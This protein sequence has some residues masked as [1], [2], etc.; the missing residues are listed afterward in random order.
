MRTSGISAAFRV[1]G[2]FVQICAVAIALAAPD[3]RVV[4]A[5]MPCAGLCL[6]TL[7]EVIEKFGNRSA[8]PFAPA[9]ISTSRAGD[10]AFRCAN[11]FRA[12]SRQPNQSIDQYRTEG[13]AL[14]NPSPISDTL[15]LESTFDIDRS[16]HYAEE[17]TDRLADVPL[18]ICA[19]IADHGSP[20]NVTLSA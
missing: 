11:D 8:F 15:L 2:E 17:L 13:C 3:W 16:R 18:R 9:I 6:V 4:R 20:R 10:P 1:Y 7:T 14:V 5:E 19:S 12:G